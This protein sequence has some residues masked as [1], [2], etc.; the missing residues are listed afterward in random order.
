VTPRPRSGNTFRKSDDWYEIVQTIKRRSSE[1]EGR[2]QKAENR[3][4][5]FV[6]AALLTMAAVGTLVVTLLIEGGIP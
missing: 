5:W 4:G 6:L 3:R 2:R 1:A